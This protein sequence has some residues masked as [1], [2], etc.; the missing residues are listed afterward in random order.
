MNKYLKP[1][2]Y[3]RKFIFFKDKIIFEPFYSIDKVNS[4]EIDKFN[5]YGFDYQE[6]ISRV[7]KILKDL[8]QVDYHLQNHMASVHWLLF[9]ALAETNKIR[10]ILEIGTFDGQTTLLLSKI[11]PDA[12]IITVDLPEDDPIF[13]SSY[14]RDNH[15]F[16]MDFIKKQLE[17]TSSD[18]VKLVKKNSFFLNEIVEQKFDLIWV[19]GGHLYPEISWDICNAYHLCNAKGWIMFDDI[20]PNKKSKKGAAI[21]NGY[22]VLE[23]IKVRMKS[24]ITYF[25]KRD[26]PEFAANPSKRNYVA[27]MQK[28]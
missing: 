27:L 17:N 18:N 13:F 28:K 25:L 2:N 9:A 24:K 14:Q 16:R 6:S 12:K 11:F 26:K 7:N 1:I 21:S 10:S 22:I 5:Q 19:D 3:W 4:I 15:D 8:D 23:Y 20:V